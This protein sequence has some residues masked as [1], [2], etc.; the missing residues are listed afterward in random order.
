MAIFWIKILD[1][2]LQNHNNYT[3]TNSS[4]QLLLIYGNINIKE[5]R[6]EEICTFEKL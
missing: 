1:K 2:I 6:Y 4:C 5:V 3:C